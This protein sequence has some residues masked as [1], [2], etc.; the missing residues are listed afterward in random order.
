[1]VA[2]WA[3]LFPVAVAVAVVLARLVVIPRL[4]RRRRARQAEHER[5]TSWMPTLAGAETTVPLY[6][7]ST[8]LVVMTPEAVAL[9]ASGKLT[10]RRKA[11]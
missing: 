8:G 6:R 1:V 9:V 10:S 4:H 7:T 11:G 3:G 5:L 2:V